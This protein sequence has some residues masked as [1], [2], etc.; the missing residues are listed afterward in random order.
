ML[1]T[2]KA[3]EDCGAWGSV[4][5]YNRPV[6]RFREAIDNSFVSTY[7]GEAWRE[8]ESAYG[9]PPEI[10]GK[11]VHLPDGTVRDLVSFGPRHRIKGKTAPGHGRDGGVEM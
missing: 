10:E 8:H 1:L 5:V 2:G 4:Q 7:I 9:A 11:Q 3:S 6:H